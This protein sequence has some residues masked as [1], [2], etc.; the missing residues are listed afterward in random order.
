MYRSILEETSDSLDVEILTLERTGRRG[1]E[2]R[3]VKAKVSQVQ[4]LK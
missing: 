3:C 4:A 1:S 2:E